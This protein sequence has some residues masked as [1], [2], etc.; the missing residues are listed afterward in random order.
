MINRNYDPKPRFF[1]IGV[2]P[3]IGKDCSLVDAL[4]DCYNQINIGDNVSFGHDCKILTGYHDK[5]R[6]GEE[7]MDYIPSKPVMIK[8]GAWIASG[9]IICPGVTVGENSVVGAGSVV[10]HDIPDNE[11]H[12]GSPCIFIRKLWD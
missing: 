1:N 2:E 4:F 5:Y 7:R 10:R 8:D 12:A 9:V 3:I 11:F 6:K